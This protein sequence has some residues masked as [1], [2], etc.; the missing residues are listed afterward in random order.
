MFVRF[1]RDA[2]A[3]DHIGDVHACGFHADAD[4][5][6]IWIGSGTFPFLHDVRGTV[7]GDDDC[8]HDDNLS[9]VA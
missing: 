8:A 9:N 7:T 3:S 6:R 1:C 5:D 4:F 2:C